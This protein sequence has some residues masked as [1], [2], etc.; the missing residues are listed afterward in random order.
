MVALQSKGSEHS[1]IL[2]AD[3]LLFDS[4]TSL[5]AKA[6][7]NMVPWVSSQQ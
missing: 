4:V 5:Y 1:C 6:V 2:F 3:E 7:L